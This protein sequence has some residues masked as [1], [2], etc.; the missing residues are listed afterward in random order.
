MVCGPPESVSLMVSHA[1]VPS[2]RWHYHPME[3]FT[4]P[5]DLIYADVDPLNGARRDA[6][7]MNEE[8]AA[9]LYLKSGDRITLS[10]EMGRLD[11]VVQTAPIAS[12]SLQVHWPEGNVLIESGPEHREPTSN[13]PDYTAIVTLERA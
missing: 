10:N 2:V 12:G 5:S 7:L 8:D 6:V 9:K 11:G 13:V 1:A 3:P 4:E